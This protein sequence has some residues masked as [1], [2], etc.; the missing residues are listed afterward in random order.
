MGR[1]KNELLTDLYPGGPTSSSP[2]N[3]FDVQCFSLTVL[4]GPDAGTAWTSR[5]DRSAL[6]SHPSND[7][8]LKDRTVSRFHCEIRLDAGGPSIVDL[9]SRNGTVVDGVRIKEAWLREG[10][11]L[12]LGQTTVSF[13]MISDRVTLRLASYTKLGSMVG[14]SVGMRA[15]FATIEKAAAVDTTVL[16]LGDTGTGKE[17]A[18]QLIHG[19]GARKEQPFIVVDCGAIPAQLL[20]SELFGHQRGAFTGAVS[21]KEGVFAAANGGTVFLD[22][23]GEMPL[24]LQP[25]VLRVLEQ[26]MIR[27]LGDHNYRQVDVRIVAA[28]NRNLREDVNEGRFRSDLFYRLAVI[29]I[30]LPPL[31]QRPEDIPLLVDCL[32]EKLGADVTQAAS[33]VTPEHMAQLKQAAWP[34]NVRELRNHLERCLAFVEVMPPLSIG[35]ETPL[36]GGGAPSFLDA[37]TSYNESRRRALDDFE[38]RYLE[39]LIERHNGNVSQAARAAEI[40]RAYLHR[41]LR[42]HGLR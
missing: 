8:I 4:E 20:E 37:N 2:T 21:P 25:K 10:S 17:E 31:R 28:T 26:K 5:G 32:L 27:P 14:Q 6:G 40:N 15:A 9:G 16:I 36:P 34:G 39:R 41:L 22:E 23:I 7:F 33:L 11:I 24:E 13:N 19:L 1:S 42:R 12:H 29:Q 3:S 18:A 38:R 30:T 35:K